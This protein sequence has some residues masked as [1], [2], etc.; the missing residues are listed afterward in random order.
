MG[1][2]PAQ[3]VAGLIPAPLISQPVSSTASVGNIIINL[4]ALVLSRLCR[5]LSPSP[6]A[7][8]ALLAAIA[9]LYGPIAKNDANRRHSA[10]YGSA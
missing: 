3:I 2:Q 1:F 8:S 10:S 6:D 7:L 5:S 4:I 9:A